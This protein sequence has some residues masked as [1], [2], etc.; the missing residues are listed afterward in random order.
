MLGTSE[1]SVPACGVGVS[2][3]NGAV[4]VTG[5][6]AALSQIRLVN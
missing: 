3:A 5:L 4:G 6:P 2:S 1:P